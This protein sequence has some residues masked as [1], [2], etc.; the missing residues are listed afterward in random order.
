MNVRR[1]A[2]LTE[3]ALL[4]GVSLTTASKAI[5]GQRRIAAA[6]RARVMEA[7]RELRFTPNPHARSLH[8][9]RTSIVG[10]LILDSSAQ[11]FAMPVM[12]GAESALTEI[13]LSMIVCDA[14]GRLDR[15]HAML[16]M[17]R[18]RT[19]DGLVVVGDNNAVWPSF[20]A[21]LDVPVVYVYGESTS[22]EDVVF[23]PDDRAGAGLALDHVVGIGRR[24]V[25]HLTGP[26]ASR[27]VAQRVAGV[28]ARLRAHGLRLAAPVGYGRWS[29]RWARH[30]L[31]ELLAE[32]PT[33][34][35][36]VCGSDQIADGVVDAAAALGIRVP[37]DLAVT[38]FDNWSTFAEETDPPLTTVDMNLE[39]L[40]A[41]AARVLFAA[42]DGQ[43][44][45]P[46]IR[47]LDC[48]LV[49]RRSTVAGEVRARG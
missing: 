2:T 19:V 10:T 21:E 7:A 12:L 17:L 8:T 26:R 45:D 9:G 43:H 4:A 28:R 15:A 46:G 27:A 30:A 36:V 3:V 11:R 14:R 33:I 6:T 49:V 1:P 31:E 32:H 34:D 13:D 25:A 47:R 41:A 42:I 5:N 29:Q 38:G 16:D 44:V 48:T 35:A 20:T 37:D 18:K 40:G 22:S 39:D 23:L 24:H